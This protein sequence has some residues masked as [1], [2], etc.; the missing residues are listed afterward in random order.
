MR[1]DLRPDPAG[2]PGADGEDADRPQAKQRDPARAL[3]R[4]AGRGPRR[5]EHR[6]DRL[7]GPRRAAED[8]SGERGDQPPGAG[9]DQDRRVVLPVGDE[10]GDGAERRRRCPRPGAPSSAADRRRA[11]VASPGRRRGRGESRRSP[12]SRRR[13][14]RSRPRAAPAPP[15]RRRRRR[16]R[17]RAGPVAQ[18]A[19]GAKGV[20][21]GQVV[22]AEQR[23]RAPLPLD[24]PGGDG[25]L[26]DAGVGRSSSTLRPQRG[27][28]PACSASLAS[29]RARAC[30]RLLVGRPAPVKRL[31]RPLVLDPQ[32]ELGELERRRA[33]RR[34]PA[35]AP[36]A[37]PTAGSG[38]DRARAGLEQLEPVVARVAISSTPDDQP[39]L[40]RRPAGDAGDEPVARRRPRAAPRASTP[41][42]QRPPG[43]PRSAPGSRRRRRAPRS[44]PGAREAA[45]SARRA[46]TTESCSRVALRALAASRPT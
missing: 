42:P 29:S 23:L 3:G 20:E 11:L 26:V 1:R 5:R 31:D 2:D 6:P 36:D 46:P 9:D 32:P 19:Q 45:R 4:Q 28:S 39:R 12:R 13:S 38:S 30:G 14:R 24:H 41:A 22:A 27:T 8:E 21:V 7:R 35:A 37:S 43:R 34:T 17:A 16:P 15:R 10:D 44:P 18:R 25:P 33:R 40:E